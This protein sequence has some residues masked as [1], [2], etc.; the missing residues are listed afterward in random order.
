MVNSIKTLISQWDAIVLTGP[1]ASGK[2]T[3]AMQLAEHLPLEII[4]MDSAQVYRGMDIGTAKPEAKDRSAVPHHLL[5]LV[6]PAQNYSAADFCKDS[7]TLLPLIKNRGRMPLIVGGT[8]LYLKALSE[9]LN[10]LPPA[11]SALRAQL[12]A[13]AAAEGWPAL[14]ARLKILDP[15]TA[16]RLAP[17]D[18]QRIQRA[19]E[20]ILLTGQAMSTLLKEKTNARPRLLHF[21][22]EPDRASRWKAIEKRFDAMLEAGFMQ[23]VEILKKRSDLH[24][25]LPSIRCV[26]YRQA[27]SY[28]EG[29]INL[30]Q[31]RE[32]SIFATRQLAKRQMTWLRSLPN[33]VVVGDLKQILQQLQC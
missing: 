2:S 22:I 26:G 5:D 11:D 18:K 33:R 13:Q 21:S 8:M 3:L 10:D 28:L 9:G 32:Q 1:T 19:L 7:C 25:D 17:L 15:I 14:H 23:E 4:S 20:I 30:T 16:A 29:K 27:W 12:E 24:A 31:M 6:D